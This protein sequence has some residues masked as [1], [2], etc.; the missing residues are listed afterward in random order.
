LEAVEKETRERIDEERA[1]AAKARSLTDGELFSFSLCA[2]VQKAN[3]LSDGQPHAVWPRDQLCAMLCARICSCPTCNPAIKRGILHV[4][5]SLLT[6][7]PLLAQHCHGA[8]RS[9]TETTT[10]HLSALRCRSPRS[11]PRTRSD[12]DQEA[13]LVGMEEGGWR[14]RRPWKPEGKQEGARSRILL[15]S[16]GGEF[17]RPAWRDS[18]KPVYSF[19]S[20]HPGESRAQTR[21][22]IQI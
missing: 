13:L 10:L 3:T 5:A 2:R 18:R 19:V 1:Q 7:G 21:L 4:A 20:G 12:T 14:I 17:G 16:L 6:I 9:S 15:A 22:R 11:L 8:S